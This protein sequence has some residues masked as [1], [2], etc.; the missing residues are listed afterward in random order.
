MRARHTQTF[1]PLHKKE[2]KVPSRKKKAP[3][4]DEKSKLT[5]AKQRTGSR[6]YSLRF[7]DSYPKLAFSKNT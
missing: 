4:R 2:K 5:G 1:A 6:P 7:F 3:K